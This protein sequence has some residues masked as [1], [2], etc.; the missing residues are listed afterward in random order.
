MFIFIIIGKIIKKAKEGTIINKIL[1]DK[2]TT[3]KESL[4]S[5]YNQ[6]NARKEV[7]GIEA[8]NPARRDDLLAISDIAT[9]IK[10]EI[11]V[12]IIK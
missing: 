5:Q 7:R 9:M 12:F 11:R 1:L 2:L 3:F 10:A 4:V 6:I 8:N